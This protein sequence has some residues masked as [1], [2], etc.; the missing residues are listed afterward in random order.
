MRN[1]AETDSGAPDTL[2]Y[3]GRKPRRKYIAFTSHAIWFLVALPQPAALGHLWCGIHK[4][5]CE[6][7][8]PPPKMRRY[9]EIR[10]KNR[11]CL[12]DTGVGE[13]TM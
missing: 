8:I 3:A 9:A 13:A 4:G 2:D 7:Q 10:P 6:K 1:D 5:T 12:V 11:R